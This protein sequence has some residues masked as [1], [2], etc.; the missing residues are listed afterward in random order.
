M[1]GA[2]G[3]ELSSI[4]VCILT[5]KRPV[6]VERC[7][8][9]L[10]EQ[11]VDGFV[12]TITVVDND[13]ERSAEEIVNR[14]AGRSTPQVTYAVEPEQ[15]ISRARNRAVA[16][17]TGDYIAFIDDDEC[18]EPSWLSR[19]LDACRR[20]GVD[21]VLG[22]VEPRYDGDSP[23]W[24]AES[25][26]STRPS[27]PTGTPLL[28][29]KYMRTGNV[30]FARSIV[31]GLAE[32]FDPKLGRSGGEDADFFERMLRAGRRF[33]WC[34]EAVV[35]EWVPP[36]R[37]TL[38]YHVRRAVIRGVTEAERHGWLSVDTLK[39]LVAISAYG[40]SLPFLFFVRY[41][42][43]ARYVVRCCDHGAKLLARAG[44]RLPD[45]RSF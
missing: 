34:N 40:L 30:L 42:L 36:E 10:C 25:G 3:S 23:M 31:V 44:F 15:N 2:H 17:S 41:S 14:F 11:E 35:H 1:N 38:N 27:F 13:G 8:A 39:S 4:A 20:H 26:L 5:Y 21:G 45:E 37:Q 16:S 28:L 7:L 6:L 29:S 32:P 9:A 33:V 19:L 18:P 22:P 43:F 24:L 12:Y